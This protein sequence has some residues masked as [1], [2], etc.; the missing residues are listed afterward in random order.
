MIPTTA[1]AAVAKGLVVGGREE[2]KKGRGVI[3]AAS[4]FCGKIS[5]LPEVAK[6]ISYLTH[7]I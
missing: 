3:K 4:M 1:G 6:V 7:S 2:G 5:I